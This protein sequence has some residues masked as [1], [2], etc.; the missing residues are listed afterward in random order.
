MRFKLAF[1]VA[2]VLVLFAGTKVVL[3]KLERGAIH[4]DALK[5]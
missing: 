2:V 3:N 1:I 4:Q 5:R